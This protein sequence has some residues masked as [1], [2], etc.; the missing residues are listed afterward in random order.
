MVPASPCREIT[1]NSV[2]MVADY[3]IP[4]LGGISEDP[5]AEALRLTLRYV[6]EMTVA[7]ITPGAPCLH[8][9]GGPRPMLDA[10]EV[11]ELG[12]LRFGLFGSASYL[13]RMGMPASMADLGRYGFVTHD[14]QQSRTPWEKWLAQTLP[15]PHRALRSD[16]E[17]THRIAIHSGLCLGFLPASALLY[18]ADLI[19]IPT[20]S[21]GWEVSMWLVVDRL[22]LRDPVVARAAETLAARLRRVWG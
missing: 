17:I 7:P 9:R 3:I 10:A 2:P 19:E 8:I 22:T 14:Q 18:Y 1:I 16:C 4:L 15:E 12:R 11:Y 20:P 6:A 13:G 5:Q 21:D